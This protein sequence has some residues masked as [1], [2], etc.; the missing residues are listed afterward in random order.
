MNHYQLQ[1]DPQGSY[2]RADGTRYELLSVKNIR[3]PQGYN[4][5]WTPFETLEA[6]LAAWGLETCTMD[7]VRCTK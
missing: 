5:G 3:T 7:D 2:C 1:P 6:C 4:V